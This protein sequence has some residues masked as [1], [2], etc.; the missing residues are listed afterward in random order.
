M[1]K[2]IKEK[3]IP[4]LGKNAW[5]THDK[6][7]HGWKHTIIVV[8]LQYHGFMGLFGI[9]S[10]VWYRALMVSF[11]FGVLYEMLTSK[12]LKDSLRDI[13]WNTIGGVTGA[14]L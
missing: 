6:F 13:V 4:L 1:I 2:W 14:I 8:F 12:D 3:F 10:M 5:F 7:A 11:V 9:T